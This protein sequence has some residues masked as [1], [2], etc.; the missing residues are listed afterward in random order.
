MKPNPDEFAKEVLWQLALLR[1]DVQEVKLLTAELIVLRTGKDGAEVQKQWR[2]KKIA[3][4][5]KFYRRAA[6]AVG[7]PESPIPDHNGD[8]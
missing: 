2:E 7:L 4:A 8:L 6:K 5:E 1:A 3:C